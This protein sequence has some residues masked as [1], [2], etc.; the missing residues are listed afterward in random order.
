LLFFLSP[1]AARSGP[2]NWR[3]VADKLVLLRAPFTN[4]G[5]IAD[6][7]IFVG[8]LVF[9]TVAIQRRWLHMPRST[10]I[11]G[12]VLLVLFL[13]APNDFKGAALIDLRPVTMLGYL[14]FAGIAEAPTLGRRSLRIGGACL[15]A[16]ILVRVG[17][18]ASIWSE[19]NAIVAQM[20]RA[21]DPIRPGSRVLVT[22][23]APA[24][25]P[26]YWQHLNAVQRIGGTIYSEYHLPALVLLERRSLWPSF[27]ADPSQQPVMV[28]PAF[29]A[30]VAPPLFV[31]APSYRELIRDNL[32]LQEQADYP[33][34]LNWQ[35]K[36]DYVLVMHAGGMPNPAHFL[37]D[38]LSL[39]TMTDIA[40]LF[41]VHP[42][43]GAVQSR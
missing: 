31:P 2:A 36:F 25:A 27:F 17:V 41:Q 10:A 34:L 13:A 35:S 5:H 43:S 8:L 33:Y 7:A 11:A 32:S 16:V 38:R 12:A 37:P 30:S 39:L 4:Y 23:V 24:D 9:V 29:H 20:R 42:L 40:A 28:R 6:S 3:P 19:Q 15:L 14:L 21:I 26:E 18:L 1:T 22:R